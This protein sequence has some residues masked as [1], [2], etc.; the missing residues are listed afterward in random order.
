[1]PLDP[2]IHGREVASRPPPDPE[3]IMTSG[4]RSAANAEA[5]RLLAEL[6]ADLK[7]KGSAA[8]IADATAHL[9]T[10]IDT[11]LKAA[12]ANLLAHH[13]FRVG[14]FEGALHYA[15][16]W[17]HYEPGN[18]TAER[19]LASA[20]IRLRRWDDAIDLLRRR[21]SRHD[22]DFE[23]HSLLCNCLGHVGRLD[24]AR[25]HGTLA[26][27]LKDASAVAPAHDL[28][29]VP[30]PPPDPDHPQRNVISFSLFG[31]N[32]RYI[33]GALANI[34][35]ARILYPTWTCR[36]HVDDALPTAIVRQFL[37]EHAE[38]KIVRGLPVEKYGTFWRFLVADDP[39]VDRFIVRD[40]DSVVSIRE[41]VAVDEW[42]VSG[43]H[44]HVMRDCYTHSELV[45]A[46][47]W[48]G[49][50]GSLPPMAGAIRAYGEQAFHHR[51]LDQQFLRE[52][53]WP[54]MRQSVLTHD[55]QFAFGERRDFPIVGTLPPGQ[56]VG[57]ADF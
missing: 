27:L 35:A 37:G 50:R 6:Y 28:S 7:S 43:C 54:T 21:V 20:L 17:H 51:T 4:S 26:L 16:L 38:V 13:H 8:R 39:T 14:N 36:F 53:I 44:F 11:S 10:D 56:H 22:D 31:T 46:G 48:G 19:S 45:L 9:D 5:R 2:Q 42:L 29:S 1:M 30:V 18:A 34:R 41:R 25:E 3:V 52:M 15:N 49:V 33:K 47:L 23:A 55:S 32:D 12:L 57:R 24:E 40:C